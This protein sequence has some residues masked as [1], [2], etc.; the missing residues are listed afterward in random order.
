[1]DRSVLF[2]TR[3]KSEIFGDLVHYFKYASSA[4]VLLCPKPNGKHLVSPFV[5][6][7]T[8]IQGFVARDEE[9]KEL[10]VALRGSV[11]VVDFLLDT[12]LVLVPFKVP[13]I[14][15][16]L[17]NP[18][19]RVHGGFLIDW[20]SV[21]LEVVGIVKQQ[22]RSHPGY[23]VV[24]VGHSLGGS[25]ASMAAV[26]LK[27][28]FPETKIRTYS[29]GAPR[30]GNKEFAQFVNRHLGMNAYRVVHTNDGVPTILPTSLGYHHHGI[31]YWETCDPASCDTTVQCSA[32]GED[33]QCSASVP[34]KGF[35]PAHA[36]YMG[37]IATTPFCL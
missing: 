9:K 14:M 24:T 10:I 20:N 18:D 32:D 2:K 28:K 16:S 3:L 34:S 7:L 6:P 25:L 23:A 19:I 35:T 1:M 12:T 31:E 15:S 11:S 37:I 33:G 30:T 22:L 21:A 27:M 8:D 13:G 17:P 5:N 29:Y 4:Y 26:T 36:V